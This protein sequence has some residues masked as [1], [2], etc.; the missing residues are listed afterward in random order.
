MA[1]GPFHGKI[2]GAQLPMT[3]SHPDSGMVIVLQRLSSAA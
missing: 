3:A 2:G 1:A